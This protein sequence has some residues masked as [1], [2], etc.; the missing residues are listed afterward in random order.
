MPWS[1]WSEI[2]DSSIHSRNQLAC[3]VKQLLTVK[4]KGPIPYTLAVGN[5]RMM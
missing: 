2:R 3:D 5:I 4:K 1:A